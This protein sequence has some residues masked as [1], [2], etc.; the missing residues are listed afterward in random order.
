M[1]ADLHKLGEGTIPAGDAS[2]GA[3][4]AAVVERR[5]EVAGTAPHGYLPHNLAADRKGLPHYS[6]IFK[7]KHMTTN[8]IPHL[9]SRL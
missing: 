2:F 3:I 8:A 7:I 6:A 9:R 5:A 4:R 1:C